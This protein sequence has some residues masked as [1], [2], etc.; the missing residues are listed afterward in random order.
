MEKHTHLFK[1]LS[2]KDLEQN[3]S[4]TIKQ[5][6]FSIETGYFTAEINIF[7]I[8]PT[9]YQSDN[10]NIK[11]ELEDAHA[12]IVLLTSPNQW[13]SQKNILTEFIKSKK[14]ENEE[15]GEEEGEENDKSDEDF[16]F[17]NQDETVII[18]LSTQDRDSQD[19]MKQF[20]WCIDNGVEFLSVKESEEINWNTK[21]SLLE[22]VDGWDRLAEALST[23]P[24]P[25]ISTKTPQMQPSIAENES[26]TKE[27]DTDDSIFEGREYLITNINF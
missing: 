23:T 19:S 20:S 5:S 4:E 3:N 11:K 21:K 17:D 22:D 24:W 8:C 14:N 13:D 9:T 18:L 26:I 25:N 7:K 16:G 1:E 2:C 6:I 10:E 27:T 15:E 12:I